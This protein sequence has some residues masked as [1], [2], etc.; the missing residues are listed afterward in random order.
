MKT[1]GYILQY[2]MLISLGWWVNYLSE[3]DALHFGS[4]LGKLALGLGVRR[5]IALDN[6]KQSFPDNNTA[7]N[8]RIIFSLY[9]N[10]GRNLVE[11]LR[12]K[13]ASCQDIENMVDLRDTEYFDRVLKN[14]RGGI[15]VS[16]HYGNW[17]LLAAAIAC[18]GY[19]FSVVV[20]PQHNKYVDEMLNSLRRSKKVNIIYKKDAAREVLT[21]LRQNRFVAMLSDQDAGSDGVFVDFL[22]Q[23]ASTTKGPAVFALK[24]GAPIITGALVRQQGGRHT[25]YLNPPFYADPKNEKQTE[26]LRL[27][28]LFTS[29]LEEFV[30]RYPDH[31]YWVHKRWKTK[32]PAACI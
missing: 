4:S 28:N 27:T 2:W 5:K 31:W 13:K 20:Y 24:T 16:S 30:R 15:L 12:F 26:I 1:F 18:K 25:G 23:K 11:L 7:E 8:H 6:L 3:R 10:L 22:G 19:P 29:Q 17:E 9:Q 32:Q 21:V 14:G